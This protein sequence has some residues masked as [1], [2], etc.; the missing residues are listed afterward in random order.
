MRLY[1]TNNI[2]KLFQ[3]ADS[4]A[5]PAPAPPAPPTPPTPLHEP[6]FGNW[7]YYYG[8]VCGEASEGSQESNLV[9]G[10]PAICPQEIDAYCNDSAFKGKPDTCKENTAFYLGTGAYPMKSQNWGNVARDQPSFKHQI[11]NFGG[12]G[13]CPGPEDGKPMPNTLCNTKGKGACDC[14]LAGAASP[15]CRKINH[16]AL[17]RS[18]P[19]FKNGCST[20]PNVVWS[21]YNINSLPLQE[22][23]IDAGYTG[24]SIDIEG[25]CMSNCN[26]GPALTADILNTKLRTYDKLTKIITVPGNGVPEENGGM[27][28]LDET[29]VSLLDFICPMYYCQIA[30]T[31]CK[32]GGGTPEDVITS[33]KTNWSGPNSK[34]KFHPGK[35]L[36][37]YTFGT[38]EGPKDYLSADILK[39]ANGGWTRWAKLGGS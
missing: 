2:D 29:T 36:L 30:D 8:T 28:W 14:S 39:L 10:A 20:Q 35:I 32:I 13:A 33:L 7:Y 6:L 22:D 31:E 3:P 19:A 25:A 38:V 4:S 37:G 34:H 9:G 1:N 21:G 24:I 11:M 23:L 12:W 18:S 17:P 15:E 27:D 26:P 16:N 5:S